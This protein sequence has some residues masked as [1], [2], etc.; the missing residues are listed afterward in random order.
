MVLVNIDLFLQQSN[1]G[2]QNRQL[3]R[4]Y[5][6]EEPYIKVSEHWY[7]IGFP[8]PTTEGKS[9]STDVPE[10]E[11]GTETDKLE[12]TSVPSLSQV[13]PKPSCRAAPESL[14]FTDRFVEAHGAGEANKPYTIQK[15]YSTTTD[16]SQSAGTYHPRQAEKQ[17]ATIPLDLIREGYSTTTG[18]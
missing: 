16:R 5:G 7:T 9:E 11:A 6:V 18:K 10:S 15:N 4:D 14:S 2:Y 13:C 8:R 17:H 3:C 12:T 1:D